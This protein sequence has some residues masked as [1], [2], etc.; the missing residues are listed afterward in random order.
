MR[1]LFKMDKKDYDQC[2][3][4]FKRDS[5]RSIIIIDGKVAMIHSLKKDQVLLLSLNR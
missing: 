5:A 3:H 4:T 2:T 1:L